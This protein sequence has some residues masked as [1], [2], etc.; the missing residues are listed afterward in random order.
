MYILRSEGELERVEP[1]DANCHPEISISDACDRRF[2]PLLRVEVT[3]RS[4]NSERIGLFEMPFLWH[5]GLYH[6]GRNIHVP[7]DGRHTLQVR[8]APP[9]FMRHDKA[10]GRR[11]ARMVAVEFKDILIKAGHK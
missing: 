1:R 6:Y 10:N 11:Y 4:L 5:P 2:I 7:E 8:I 9:T 3:L